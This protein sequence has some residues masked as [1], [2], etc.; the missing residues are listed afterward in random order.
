[1]PGRF[2][3]FPNCPNKITPVTLRSLSFH[4]VPTADEE[5]MKRWLLVLQMDPNTTADI[6][7][8]E[9]HKV[10]SVHFDPDDFYPRKARPAPVKKRRKGLRKIKPLRE[11][12][13]RTKLKPHAVPK[14]C[15][16]SKPEVV[17]TIIQMLLSLLFFHIFFELYNEFARFKLRETK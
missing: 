9:D 16:S 4:R 10:C 7:K 5:L 2:C 15:L 11:H 1:M 8:R 17:F 13:E 14:S 3:S 6:V 12:F